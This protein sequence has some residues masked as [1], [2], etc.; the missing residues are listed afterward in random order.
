[1]FFH[2]TAPPWQADG[3]A[4]KGHFG[5]VTLTRILH[6]YSKRTYDAF[7]VSM[8]ESLKLDIMKV[9]QSK[10]IAWELHL[11]NLREIVLYEAMIQ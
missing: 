11:A 7:C 3:V 4:N 8:H 2:A 10:W 9:I 5:P 6:I 1:M